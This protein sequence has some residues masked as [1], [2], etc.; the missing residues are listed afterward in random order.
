MFLGK[1]ILWQE[2]SSIGASKRQSTGQIGPSACFCKLSFTATEPSPYVYKL[3]IPVFV[4]KY[5]NCREVTKMY[6]K[7]DSQNL[8]YL[9][10][11]L[12]QK[13]WPTCDPADQTIEN[14]SS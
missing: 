9:L 14:I 2:Q 11:G 12:F 10:S 1:V 4:L 8:K 7:Y 3:F 13:S 5:W 6:E